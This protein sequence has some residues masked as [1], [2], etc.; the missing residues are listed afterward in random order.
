M[1]GQNKQLT[2]RDA[3]K[4]LGAVAGASML[5]NLPTKW[6][7]P[8]LMSGVLPAHAQTSCNSVL[9]EVLEGN[10]FV[11]VRNNA[12]QPDLVTGDGGPGSTLV[13]VCRDECLFLWCDLN[14]NLSETG[15][16]RI[17]TLAGQF[18]ENYDVMDSLR[19]I[20]IDMGSGEYSNEF[21]SGSA[22]DCSWGDF[23][24]DSKERARA[25]SW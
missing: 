17:T 6:S 22:G 3:I 1:T 18:I 24:P 9:I 8:S 20:V 21:G 5:A 10:F 25:T 12:P 2:R 15:S 23:A 7:K 16:V 11:S 4:L 19:D 13:W 14:A